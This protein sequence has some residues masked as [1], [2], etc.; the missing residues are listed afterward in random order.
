MD[1]ELSLGEARAFLLREGHVL[2]QGQP[3]EGSTVVQLT[4][5]EVGDR[6]CVYDINDHAEGDS[7][8]RHQFGCEIIVDGDDTLQ[9]TK[10]VVWSPEVALRQVGPQSLSVQVTQPVEGPAAPLLLRIF[11]EHGT[12]LAPVILPAAGDSFSITVVLTQPVPPLHVQLLRAG[13]ARAAADAAR[14]DRGSRHRW[15]RGLWPG[16]RLWRRA[17]L[18]VGRRRL[19]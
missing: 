1:D 6:L 11:P 13:V 12:G 9:L 2:E 7:M 18:L 4:G 17:G 5:A 15:G 10:N 8:P 3:A 14:G 19:V 16:A